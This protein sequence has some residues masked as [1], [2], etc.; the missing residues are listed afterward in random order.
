MTNHVLLDNVSHKDLRVQSGVH[1]RD[2]ATNVARVVPSE[3]GY[4]QAEYPLFFVRNN[5]TQQFEIM[6]LLGFEEGENLYYENGEWTANTCPLTIERQPFLIGFQQQ[7]L[8]GYPQDVPVVTIDMEHPLVNHSDG[9]F[10][11]LEHGG[12][13]DYLQTKTSILKTIFDGYSASEQFAQMLLGL[14][15]IE[16]LELAFTFA[17]DSQHTLTGLHTIHEERL[18]TLNGEALESLHQQGYLKY[19]YM[20]LASLPNVEHLT[21]AKNRK[22]EREKAGADT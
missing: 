16:P 1:A 19:V 2:A 12:E 13:S 5:D 14:E 18:A 6:A 8:D 9:E 20:M 10:L 22:I 7:E 21:R 17:D 11:F 3:L 4:L 15:L